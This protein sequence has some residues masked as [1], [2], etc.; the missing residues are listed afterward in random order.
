MIWKTVLSLYSL[1]HRSR[2][3]DV[4]YP[5]LTTV[6]SPNDFISNLQN[7][8]YIEWSFFHESSLS[9]SFQ[10]FQ[11]K[12]T[13]KDYNAETSSQELTVVSFIK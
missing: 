10:Y 13:T 9:P 2:T 11:L 5:K 8:T 12:S 6:L 4:G 1:Q 7:L 3:Q